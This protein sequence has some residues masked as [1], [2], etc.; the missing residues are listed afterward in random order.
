[1]LFRSSPLGARRFSLDIGQIGLAIAAASSSEEIQ[2]ARALIKANPDG[3][4]FDYL[5]RRGLWG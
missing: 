1:M 2:E 4:V 5:Q 3:W